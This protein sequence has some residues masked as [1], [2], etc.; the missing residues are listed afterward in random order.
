VLTSEGPQ[1]VFD[2]DADD[3]IAFLD[4]VLENFENADPRLILA[5]GYSRGAQVAMR[6]AQRDS[7][8]RGV[9]EFSGMSDEWTP[10]GQGYISDYLATPQ[11]E[12][13]PAD[14]Y[15]HALWELQQGL[16]DV[17]QARA[18]LMKSSIVYHAA[19]LPKLQIHHGVLDTACPIGEADRLVSVLRATPNADYECF[20][21]E[22]GDH[23][24]GSLVGAGDRMEAFL[25]SFLE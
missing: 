22:N 17:W 3:T 23:S 2:R 20:R 21:Y 5:T 1:S 6:V 10:N 4:C 18:A 25:R 7:R 8:I 11:A 16:C 19:R 13:D 24:I 9:V 15:Y 12:P 14:A